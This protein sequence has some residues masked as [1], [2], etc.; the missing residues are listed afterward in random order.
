[1]DNYLLSTYYVPDRASLI[2]QLVKN[3]PAM[4]ET[5]VQFLGHEDPLEKAEATHSN[6]LAWRIPYISYMYICMYTYMF[7]YIHQHTYIS[8]VP[9][10]TKSWT[11]L[12]YFH[13]HSNGSQDS[14]P[15]LHYGF[16]ASLPLFQQPLS[17]FISKCLNLPCPLEP[18]EGYGGWMKPISCKQE[19]GDTEAL[20][21]PTGY[22][23][24]IWCMIQR[25]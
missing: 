15:R 3:L 9:G 23:N 5:L 4:Q 1:M 17:S 19:M 12:S 6:I 18:R 2:A 20:S 24:Y 16:W 10:V 13:F 22:R 25:Q 11:R 21:Y 7:T 14:S 8:I